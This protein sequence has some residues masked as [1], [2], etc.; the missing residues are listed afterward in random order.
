MLPEI[1]DM[2]FNQAA[3]VI[4]FYNWYLGQ[5]FY[6]MYVKKYFSRRNVRDFADS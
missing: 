6:N 1:E 5:L 3:Y 4:P 2:I